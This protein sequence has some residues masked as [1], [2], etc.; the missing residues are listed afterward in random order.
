V[1]D[2]LEYQSVDDEVAYVLDSRGGAF[3]LA[4]DN[5]RIYVRRTRVLIDLTRFQES[6]ESFFVRWTEESAPA[7][8]SDAEIYVCAVLDTYR[9]ARFRS[10]KR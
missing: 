3:E 10:R 6:V 1:I 7:R 2:H 8:S 9:H 5:E 4:V